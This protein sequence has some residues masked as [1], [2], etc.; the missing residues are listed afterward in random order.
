MNETENKKPETPTELLVRCMEE[1]GEC[2]A[3]KALIIYLDDKDFIKWRS[4][5]MLDYEKLGLIKIVEGGILKATEL[6]D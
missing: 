4:T 6:M 2:E 1:F 5:P 3:R